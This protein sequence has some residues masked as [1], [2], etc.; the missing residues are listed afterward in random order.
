MTD[1]IFE[2]G[3]VFH[4]E[5]DQ[6]AVYILQ[7]CS[8]SP[9]EKIRNILLDSYYSMGVIGAFKNIAEAIKVKGSGEELS[10]EIIE[11][12]LFKDVEEYGERS[13]CLSMAEWE[14]TMFFVHNGLAVP[15]G[16]LP[17]GDFD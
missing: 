9:N 11:D 15:G 6:Q 10:D 1:I 8:S 13:M 4:I 17:W 3:R 2:N 5:N 14:Y 16:P 7:G 12:C